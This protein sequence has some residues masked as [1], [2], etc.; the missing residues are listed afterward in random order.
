MKSG[1]Y[2]N[3]YMLLCENSTL[4]QKTAQLSMAYYVL[5]ILVYKAENQVFRYI[6]YYH[7]FKWGKGK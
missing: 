5:D 7:N 6:K 2:F 4:K 1:N 3:V